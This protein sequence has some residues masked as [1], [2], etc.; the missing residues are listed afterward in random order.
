MWLIEER[1]SFSSNIGLAETVLLDCLRSYRQADLNSSLKA[2]FKPIFS[3]CFHYNYQ[4]YLS[5]TLVQSWLGT[6]ES[7][8]AQ[9]CPLNVLHSVSVY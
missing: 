8:F 9:A 7:A 5:C 1:A 3:D 6:Y 4:L 2:C